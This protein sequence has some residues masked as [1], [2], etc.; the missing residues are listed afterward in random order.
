MHYF[1]F[2]IFAIIMLAGLFFVAIH[3]GFRAPRNKETR[4]P[5]DLL[6]IDYLQL[7]IPISSNKHQNDK[8]LFGWLLPVSG[9]TETL[10][11]LHG[12]GGN[13]EVMLPLATPFYKAGI[14]VLLFD[15]RSH[16]SSDS[17]TFSSLPRFAEDL[18]NVIDWLKQHHPEKSKSIALLGHSIGAGAVLFEASKRKDIAAVI[19]ISAFAHP[20]WMMQRFL[21]SFYL[22][23]V[24]R[25]LVMR[26][27]E[28][29]IGHRFATFAPLATVCKI[30]C[31]ILIV[32]GKEDT[33]IPVEDAR[34]IIE[35]CPEPHLSLLEIE[36]A[37]HDSV[38]KIELHCEKLINFLR[39]SG[40]QV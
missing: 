21:K 19:S 5:K 22:P 1:I 10:I 40:F 33:T 14:N 13:A 20:E 28:W 27:V 31:P 3:L 17:D 15:T 25:K 32:H 16:G 35:H 2:S 34:A 38:E 37:K 12:W 39:T 23:A 7:H 18:G 26:Y 6:G 4:N 11:I 30:N 36:D 8:Q 29:V 24:I 9:S